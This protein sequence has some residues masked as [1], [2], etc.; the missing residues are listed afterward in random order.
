VKLFYSP[1][2]PFVR[3]VLACAITREIHERIELL[4][5]NPHVQPP[6]LLGAN[7]LSKVPCL[8]T[9]DGMALFDSPVICEY[10]DSL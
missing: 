7:P 10:L 5:T 2:S 3:K 9:A 6:Q 8:I 4:P 1:A